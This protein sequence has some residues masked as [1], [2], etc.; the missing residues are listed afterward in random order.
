MITPR[1]TQLSK[2]ADA[3]TAEGSYA[4]AINLYERALDGT[5]ASADIHYKLALIYDDKLKDPL[6]ALHHFKRFLALE[7]AGKRAQEVKGFMKRDE[8]TL[9]TNLT[10]DSMVPRAEVVRLRNE[11]LALRK[12]IA[13]RWAAKKAA[14]AAEKIAAKSGKP[15]ENTKRSGKG[16]RYTVESGDTLASIARKFYNSSAGWHR[17]LEANSDTISKPADLKPG[18]ELVIP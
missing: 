17:I 1:Q 10:G 14:A 15:N 6:N 8:L 2:D 13:E 3:K 18:Q 7:S 11:N 12:Q 5:P 9:L 4:E 16:R